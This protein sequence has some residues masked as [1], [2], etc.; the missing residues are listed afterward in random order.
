CLWFVVLSC[1]IVGA[2]PA[3]R[4]SPRQAIAV[5]GIALFA[6]ALRGGGSRDSFYG[7]E[8][9]DA[10]VYAAA[11]RQSAWIKFSSGFDGLSVC[12]V[13]SLQDCSESEV[14]PGHLPGFPALLRAVQT[15]VGY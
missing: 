1:G 13:G 8:Y 10:Y 14:F 12:A 4:S 6:L 7:L 15:A 5:L 11:A 2:W 3:I 9:E